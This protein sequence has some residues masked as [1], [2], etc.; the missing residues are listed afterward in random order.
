MTLKEKIN[1]ANGYESVIW[2]FACNGLDDDTRLI[3]IIRQA[4]DFSIENL[5][6]INEG[7]GQN[8]IEMYW[9]ETTN[10]SLCG[11]LATLLDKEKSLKKSVNII[12]FFAELALQEKWRSNRADFIYIL[13]N[14][15]NK[16]AIINIANDENI[17]HSDGFIQ[18]SLVEAIYKLKISG[19]NQQFHQMK[20]IAE[21]DGDKQ[22]LKY[23]TK[24]LERA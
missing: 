14:M 9:F 24:Y 3:A 7:Y 4:L 16:E 18:F 15:K 23:I 22:M 12:H 11:A 17:W 13:M 6:I 2:H 8:G 19:F 21:K 20:N 5:S 10:N 1:R